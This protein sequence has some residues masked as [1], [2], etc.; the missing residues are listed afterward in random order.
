VLYFILFKEY[1]V[2]KPGCR[3]LH[4]HQGDKERKDQGLFILAVERSVLIT[5][6]GELNQGVLNADT[7]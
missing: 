6:D 2:L 1:A 5:I 3:Y 7:L 4:A